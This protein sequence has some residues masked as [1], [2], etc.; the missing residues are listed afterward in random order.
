MVPGL[1]I[2]AV[3]REGFYDILKKRIVKKIINISETHIVDDG[4][5]STKIDLIHKN[6]DALDMDFTDM[7]VLQLSMP[8]RLK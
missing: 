5:F 1:K 6:Y 8:H 4:S 7:I 2:F 3:L